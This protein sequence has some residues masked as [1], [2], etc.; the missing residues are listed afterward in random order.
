MSY[1][2]IPCLHFQYHK[3]VPVVSN[4]VS[5]CACVCNVSPCPRVK[6]RN[7][8]SCS[9]VFVTSWIW[10]LHPET[11]GWS[12]EKDRRGSEAKRRSSKLLA[13]RRKVQYEDENSHVGLTDWRRTADRLCLLSDQRTAETRP[14][15]WRGGPQS[16]EDDDQTEGELGHTGGLTDDA[17]QG[18]LRPA[19]QQGACTQTHKAAWSRTVGPTLPP[20]DPLNP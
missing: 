5:K 8:A 13:R 16:F 18:G 4:F 10:N 9:C 19:Q 20:R 17:L 12:E 1:L 15:A 6:Y 7:G 11:S 3:S 14:R 2:L